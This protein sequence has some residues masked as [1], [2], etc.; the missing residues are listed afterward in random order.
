M[1]GETEM[2][3][4]NIKA[5]RDYIEKLP[6]NSRFSMSI[7]GDWWEGDRWEVEKS[8]H[9]I[10]CMAGHTVLLFEGLDSFKQLVDNYSPAVDWIKAAGKHLG[11][12]ED[13]ANALFIPNDGAS[14]DE[15]TLYDA[16]DTL[17][18]LIATG[19]ISYQSP[20][21]IGRRLRK[22]GMRV[23]SMS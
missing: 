20:E 14:I 5:L 10:G 9:T 16:L 18:Y 17:D 12:T 22:T 6:T 1:E 15:L 13:E 7:W 21:H 2:N 11:L 8:C 3:T 23:K 4:E 19:E